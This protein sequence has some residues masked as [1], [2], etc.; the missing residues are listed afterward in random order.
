MWAARTPMPIS[1]WRKAHGNTRHYVGAYGFRPALDVDGEW[2]VS[3]T[4]PF[5][6]VLDDAAVAGSQE[7]LR[8]DDQR[9]R[10]CGAHGAWR[11][12]DQAFPPVRDMRWR[13]RLPMSWKRLPRLH[14]VPELLD[15]TDRSPVVPASM[16]LGNLGIWRDLGASEIRPGGV[17]KAVLSSARKSPSLSELMRVGDR[18]LSTG[19]TRPSVMPRR[20][21]IFQR[22]TLR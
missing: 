13:W 21:W 18:I 8:D 3:H 10:E 20:G 4:A 2:T 5:R 9:R 12:A 15:T 7:R 1:D 19:M 14:S 11:R 6:H 17:T 22:R 16:A